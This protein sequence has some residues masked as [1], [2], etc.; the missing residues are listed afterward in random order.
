MQNSF[1]IIM[2]KRRLIR[3]FITP[4]NP[5]SPASL[6]TPPSALRYKFLHHRGAFPYVPHRR[7]IPCKPRMNMPALKPRTLRLPLRL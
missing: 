5:S 6:S 7:L 1:C 3:I 2:Q 4:Q